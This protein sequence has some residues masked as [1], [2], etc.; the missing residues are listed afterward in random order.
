MNVLS[1]DD[2]FEEERFPQEKVIMVIADDAES[3]ENKSRIMQKWQE[4]HQNVQEE[5]VLLKIKSK[6]THHVYCPLSP[7]KK[8]KW[9]QL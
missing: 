5:R 4:V 6:K 7:T 2:D 3:G 8:R 9:W 1:K